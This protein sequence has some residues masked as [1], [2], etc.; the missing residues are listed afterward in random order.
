MKNQNKT[1]YQGLY[2][3]L[4]LF[5][6]CLLFIFDRIAQAA[7]APDTTPPTVISTNP[8]N[9]ATDV[10]INSAITATFSERMDASTI[11]TDTFTV[12]VGSNKIDGT[13][14][15]NGTIATYNGTT[16]TFNGMAATFT[17]SKNLLSSTTYTVEI[18]TDVKDLAG[19]A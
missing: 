11:T 14:S 5:F 6:V 4:F 9:G 12:S 7:P 3:L 18:T 2:T 13:I 10:A 15:Y 8:V 17:P 1:K 19:N 16:A